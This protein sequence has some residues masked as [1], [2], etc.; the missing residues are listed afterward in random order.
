MIIQ[1]IGDR[2]KKGFHEKTTQLSVVTP[3]KLEEILKWGTIW[4]VVWNIFYV[5]IIYGIILPID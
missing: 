1:D 3:E 4:L 5:P 2:E